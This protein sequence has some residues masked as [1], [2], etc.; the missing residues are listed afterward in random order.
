MTAT[1]RLVILHGD[2]V[3][4]PRDNSR[5]IPAECHSSWTASSDGQ[6]LTEKLQT[7]SLTKIF[8]LVAHPVLTS[9]AES[10]S[11]VYIIQLVWSVYSMSL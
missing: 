3:I 6:K 11:R 7:F 9:I 1:R 10:V 4:F 2:P 5:Q 8:Q